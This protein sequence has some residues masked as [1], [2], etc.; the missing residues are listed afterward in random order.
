MLELKPNC[1]WC[2]CDL[3]PDSQEAQICSYECTYCA[4]CVDNILEN[5]C[6]TCGGGFAMR[7]IRPTR[8]EGQQ[9]NLGLKNRPAG[10]KR[11]HSSWTR[12]QVEEVRDRLKDTPPWER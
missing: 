7:P 3:P 6:P 5:V 8:A 4:S 9:K 10:T 1:E 12:A 2:D 11:Y